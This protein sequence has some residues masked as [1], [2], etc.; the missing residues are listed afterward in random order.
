MVRSSSWNWR[1]K[2]KLKFIDSFRFLPESLSKLASL[3]PK[4][5]KRVLY[6][7]GQ[8]KYSLD[9]LAM[10][11]R[12]GIFPYDYIDSLQRLKETSLP[13]KEEFYSELNYEE[14]S[15]KD[16][17]FACNVWQKFNIKTLGEYSDLYL[18]TDVL[19]LADV[20]ENF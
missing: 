19:L 15:D 17:E 2:I 6:G 5:K 7:E 16:Y 3:V 12:K 14:I 20:F 1:E 18:K 9:Q 8:K 13:S 11:E 4:N 10:L